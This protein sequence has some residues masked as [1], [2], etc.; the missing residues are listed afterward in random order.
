MS[1]WMKPTQV[2]KTSPMN[3][4]ESASQVLRGITKWFLQLP[5]EVSES[6]D[7]LALWHEIRTAERQLNKSDNSVEESEIEAVIE[8]ALS[9]GYSSRTE[10]K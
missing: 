9:L 1:P 8:A 2:S 5:N 7:Y 6:P 4:G 10:T 3:S